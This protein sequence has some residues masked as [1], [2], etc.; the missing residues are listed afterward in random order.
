MNAGELAVDWLYRE[1]LHVDDAWSVRDAKG[2][3]WWAN[4]N[5]QRI[6][7]IG[8]ETNPAGER[9]WFVRVRTELLREL[10]LTDQ[11]VAHINDYMMGW[12]SLS[13]PVYDKETCTLHLS[14]VLP[15]HDGNRDWAQSLLSLAALLQIEEAQLIGPRAVDAFGAVFAVSGHPQNGLRSQPDELAHILPFVAAHGKEPCAWRQTELE[16]VAHTYIN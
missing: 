3:S 14:S 10:Q 2:F 15:I 16:F 9:A 11:A 13:G 1:S 4:Q 7:V 5:A 6:E 12:P 8:S